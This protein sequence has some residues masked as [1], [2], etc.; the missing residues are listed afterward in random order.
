M[1]RISG[2]ILNLEKHVL[3]ALRGIYG[4]GKVNSLY[5][6]KMAKTNPHTK[7]KNLTDIEITSLQTT[8]NDFEVEGNLRTR[9]RLNI[10]RL[11]DIKSYKGLRHKSNLPVRGQRT[12]T[13]AKTRKKIKKKIMVHNEKKNKKKN[14]TH[15]ISWQG[16]YTSI[17]Q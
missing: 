1:V 16:I 4:I 7:V 9:I 17:I 11:I 15:Y 3:I 10:K 6:C 14:K 12:R 5:I 13:N 2:V 8:I